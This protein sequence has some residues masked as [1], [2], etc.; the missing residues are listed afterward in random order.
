MFPKK[1]INVSSWLTHLQQNYVS[2]FKLYLLYP[3]MYL[4]IWWDVASFCNLVYTE[5]YFH[6]IIKEWESLKLHLLTFNDNVGTTVDNNIIS[7]THSCLS[8]KKQKY[9]RTFKQRI[10]IEQYGNHL[11]MFETAYILL[12]VAHFHG[13]RPCCR[14]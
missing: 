5:L 6:F 3:F 8:M 9:I 12:Y 4:T 11:Q 2:W 1:D 13:F 7:R 10:N 14:Q